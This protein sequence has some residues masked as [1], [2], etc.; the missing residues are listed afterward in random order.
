MSNIQIRVAR[1]ETQATNIRAFELVLENSDA[2]PALSAEPHIDVHVSKNLVGQ[3]SGP[4]DSLERDRYM[5]GVRE[6]NSRGVSGSILEGNQEGNIDEEGRPR[7]HVPLEH[8]TNTSALLADGIHQ[9][10]RISYMPDRP[11]LIVSNDAIRYWA[12]S[13]ACIQKPHANGR[14]Y[15]TMLQS[16]QRS[17][18]LLE[19]FSLSL[20]AAPKFDRMQRRL[21]RRD[22]PGEALEQRPFDL[23]QQPD[24]LR[25]GRRGCIQ[26]IHC[27]VDRASGQYPHNLAQRVLANLQDR[28]GPFRSLPL[29]G[30][31]G[32]SLSV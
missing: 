4:N 32:E 14:R 21:D 30:L 29:E 22:A 6:A 20:V 1:K 3:R 25:S 19:P 9:V 16:L 27:L 5:M 26:L 15:A 17:Q 12:G 8:W 13:P 11:L 10:A 28:L 2:L 7:N 31:T 24:L 23:T 18:P